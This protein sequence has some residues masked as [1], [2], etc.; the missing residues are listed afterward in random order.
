MLL[1]KYQRMMTSKP[2][3]PL[4][5]INKPVAQNLITPRL[6]L[7]LL[8]VT[9]YDDLKFVS[10]LLS[11][12]A[13]ESMSGSLP[14]STVEDTLNYM[15]TVQMKPA[16]CNGYNGV[17]LYLIYLRS[18]SFVDQYKDGHTEWPIGLVNLCQRPDF[19]VPDMG[20]GFWEPYWGKGYATE[21]ARELLRS[22]T[23]EMGLRKVLLFTQSH[24]ARSMKIAEKLGFQRRN[25]SQTEN[26]HDLEIF[27]IGV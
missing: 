3:L 8:D 10:Y 18:E 24:N 15:S 27:S 22:I 25:R 11:D 4:L 14:C 21:A 16:E 1:I 7:R 5:P 26:E 17:L 23:E 9:S 19:N 2:V 12:P 20:Y 6:H 13:V